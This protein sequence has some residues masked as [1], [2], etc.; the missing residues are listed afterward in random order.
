MT[1]AIAAKASCEWLYVPPGV[2]IVKVGSTSDSVAMGNSAARPEFAPST[3]K[4]W[5][6]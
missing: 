5:T 4:D 1:D 6:P 2:L 3:R